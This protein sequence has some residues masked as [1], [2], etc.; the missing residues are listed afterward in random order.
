[1]VT[2]T[3][4]NKENNKEN[5]RQKIIREGIRKTNA[6]KNISWQTNALN[7]L[8]IPSVN[9]NN[10]SWSRDTVTVDLGS[11][12]TG[13][14]FI[15]VYHTPLR[16]NRLFNPF[17]DPVVT[18]EPI[19]QKNQESK[20]RKRQE[21]DIVADYCYS[22]CSMSTKDGKGNTCFSSEKISHGRENIF[23]DI[24]KHLSKRPSCSTCGYTTNCCAC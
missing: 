9:N 11:R 5:R 7:A 16:P 19:I 3:E 17:S 18:I 10:N 13:K 1:M 2:V 24:S 12:R 14:T 6:R 20:K 8:L 4:N 15:G 22:V 23:G 21:V